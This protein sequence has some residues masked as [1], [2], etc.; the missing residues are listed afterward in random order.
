MSYGAES[1]L[2]M[3]LRALL[4]RVKTL[5]RAPSDSEAVEPASALVSLWKTSPELAMDLV[6]DCASELRWPSADEVAMRVRASRLTAQGRVASEMLW[7]RWARLSAPDHRLPVE[8]QRAQKREA[9]KLAAGLE[10]RLDAVYEGRQ[11]SAE[12]L[13]WAIGLAPQIEPWLK[14]GVG[15]A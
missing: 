13:E 7:T 9:R 4:K 11:T 2:K 3:E 5:G 8:E 12:F 1:E 10:E 6:E 14:K 15:D